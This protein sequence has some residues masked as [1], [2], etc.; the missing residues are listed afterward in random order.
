MQTEV[1]VYPENLLYLL[2][3]AIFSFKRKML[4]AVEQGRNQSNTIV[5]AAYSIL[6][7]YK[8][9]YE[10]NILFYSLRILY[11]HKCKYRLCVGHKIILI[12]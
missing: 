2:Q 1:T 6:A 5:R 4:M 9:I 12:T 7:A 11:I 3:V 10:Y 8:L